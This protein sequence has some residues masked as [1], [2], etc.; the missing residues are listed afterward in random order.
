MWNR[1]RSG[2]KAQVNNN[3][4]NNLNQSNSGE[5]QARKNYLQ[6]FVNWFFRISPELT[7]ESR[8]VMLTILV[9]SV[10]RDPVKK[11]NLRELISVTIFSMISTRRSTVKK[12]IIG[13]A[14]SISS[15]VHHFY[16]S[17]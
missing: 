13:E 12:T 16:P 6:K 1:R 4:N 5:E 17:Y 9:D 7:D 11:K 14:K 2:K 3:N 15:K 8:E 10:V